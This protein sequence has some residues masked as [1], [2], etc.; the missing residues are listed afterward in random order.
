MSERVYL[1]GPMSNLPQ[2]NFPAFNEASLRLRAKGVA[3]VSPHELDSPAIQAA[4]LKSIDGAL[5]DGKVAGE[6]WGAILARDVQVVADNIDAVAFLPGWQRSR[7][8]KLEAVVGL[9]CGHK[10]YTYEDGNLV[11]KGTEWV[12]HQVAVNL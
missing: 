8:A 12:K 11:P 10:F 4:S 9:L 6:T 1:A 7:G 3:V 2:F 5:E